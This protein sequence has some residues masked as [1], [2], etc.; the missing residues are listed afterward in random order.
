MHVAKVIVI[1]AG[2][3]GLRAARALA[4]AGVEVMV[5]EARD[6]V[7]GRTWTRPFDGD[8]PPVEIGGSWFT[9]EHE[10]VPAE[11][12][13]YGIEV[14]SWGAPAVCRWRTGGV[15][16]ESLPVP[17]EQLGELERALA[18]LR[19]DA[20]VGAR[21]GWSFADYLAALSLPDEVIEFVSAWWVMIGGTAPDRG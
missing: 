4:E 9:A 17:F 6:R 3:A 5:L 14:R 7:G 18:T 16:R 19:A 10:L 21:G 12:A 8:G 20:D 11:L 2:F 1:G 13:R 15:L